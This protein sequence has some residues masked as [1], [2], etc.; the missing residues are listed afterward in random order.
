MPD[1]LASKVKEWLTGQGYPLEMYTLQKCREA[2]MTGVPSWYY[3]DGES[4]DPEYQLAIVGLSWFRCA[5][6]QVLA[7][8]GRG[9]FFLQR[10]DRCSVGW[11]TASAR[12][13]P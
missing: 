3:L 11:P 8:R 12:I 10:I 5:A 6:V 9:N 7:Q 2:G 4:A 1:P 13:S